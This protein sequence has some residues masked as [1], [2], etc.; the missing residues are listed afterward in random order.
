MQHSFG[1]CIPY[2]SDARIVFLGPFEVF[3]D[4]RETTRGAKLKLTPTYMRNAPSER[5]TTLGPMSLS[6]KM[7]TP[8]AV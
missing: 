6:C 7:F 2:N 1:F 8:L 3:E 5:N 4:G